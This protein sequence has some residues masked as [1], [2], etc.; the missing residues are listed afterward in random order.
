MLRVFSVR[1]TIR[2]LFGVKYAELLLPWNEAH[3]QP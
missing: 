1:D 2:A 3:G